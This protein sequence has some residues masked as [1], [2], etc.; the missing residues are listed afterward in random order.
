MV[1]RKN[2]LPAVK[3]KLR[4]NKMVDYCESYYSTCGKCPYLVQCPEL[5]E[6]GVSPKSGVMYDQRSKNDREIITR[7][8]GVTANELTKKKIKAILERSS[9]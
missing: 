2:L 7:I 4:Y 5:T 1:M 6:L 8:L 9:Q 3:A